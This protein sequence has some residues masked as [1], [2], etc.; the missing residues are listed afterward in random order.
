M[1]PEQAL[2]ITEEISYASDIHA[3]GVLMFELFLLQKPF[4]GKSV[5]ELLNSII[6]SEPPSLEKLKNKEQG[7]VPIEIQYIVN[8]ALQKQP[9]L[10]HQSAAAL[11]A[12]I[13]LFLDGKYPIRCPHTALKR[14]TMEAGAFG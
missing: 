4:T 1:S 9:A 2:G 8:K 6:N 5:Y 13:Q 14:C 12:E 7:V 3:I 11:K 10:R